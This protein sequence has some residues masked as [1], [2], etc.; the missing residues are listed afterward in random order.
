MSEIDVSN[1]K[2]SEE[3]NLSPDVEINGRKYW[4]S[5]AQQL[6]AHIVKK[7]YDGFRLSAEYDFSSAKVFIEY[8]IKPATEYSFAKYSEKK[9]IGNLL[10]DIDTNKIILRKTAVDT[11]VHEFHKDESRQMDE[12][13]GVQYEIF[14]YLRDSDTIEIHAIERK[15]RHKEKFIYI[16]SKLKAVRNGRFLH[17]RGYGVQFFIPKADFKCYAKGRVKESKRKK[18]AKCKKN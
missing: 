10:F 11:E 9:C 12:C 15:V 7:Y 17:F 16:I 5:P 3:L 2:T 13:F 18:E 4:Y 14:K 1:L 8:L 6:A